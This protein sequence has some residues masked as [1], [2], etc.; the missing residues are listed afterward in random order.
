VLPFLRLKYA[1][2]AVAVALVAWHVSRTERATRTTAAGD[3][4][5]SVT[6]DAVV[7]M[8]GFASLVVPFVMTSA[9]ENHLFLGG[10]FLILFLARDRSLGFRL[11]AHLLLAIQFLNLYG[12]YGEHPASIAR[13][14]R[15]TYSQEL[16]LGYSLV[17]VSCFVLILWRLLSGRE[18]VEG[19]REAGPDGHRAAAH[20]GPSRPEGGYRGPHKSGGSVGLTLS[21]EATLAT[22]PDKKAAPENE[23]QQSS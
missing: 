19:W 16:A 18:Q 4:A 8:F 21:G 9:H 22:G 12:L 11:A 10:L 23:T 6:S 2:A 17:S 7:A 20:A 1:A 14:L 5:S 15:D 3:G 13:A